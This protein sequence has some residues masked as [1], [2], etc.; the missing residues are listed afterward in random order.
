MIRKEKVPVKI[1]KNG[2][3]IIEERTVESLVY[4]E[5]IHIF[6]LANLLKRTIIVL[7]LDKIKDL[8]PSNIRGIYL[9]LLIKP[10][11]CVKEPILIAFHNFHFCPLLYANYDEKLNKIE[12][13]VNY[14]TL[15]AN[16][17]ANLTKFNYTCEE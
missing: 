14:D 8:Q 1:S 17:T 11:E 16:T 6:T 2:V 13:G 15:F 9:P 3:E 12:K 5:D 7:A 10:S 4:L